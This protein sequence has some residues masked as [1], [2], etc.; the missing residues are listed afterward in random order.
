MPTI[1][2]SR[3]KKFFAIRKTRNGK[4][5]FTRIGFGEGKRLFEVKGRF[6]TCDEDDDMDETERSNAYRFDRDLFISP[7]DRLADMVNHSCTPNA[8]VVK[9]NDKLYVYSISEILKGSEVFIDYSTIIAK[10]DIWTMKCN[11]GS[12]K[13]RKI[14]KNFAKLSKKTQD[15]YKKNKIVPDFIL[16]IRG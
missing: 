4:G 6:V 16:K 10:D 15:I 12:D 11:C 7:K 13:C 1:L 2:D 9:D 3:E 8:K 14:V 5:V